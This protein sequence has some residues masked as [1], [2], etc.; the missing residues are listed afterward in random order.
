M[1][2]DQKRQEGITGFALIIPVC[3]SFI[4]TKTKNTI[5]D[6]LFFF[7]ASHTAAM[8]QIRCHVGSV[9]LISKCLL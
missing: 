8:P 9:T 2:L 5:N 6:C 1:N 7:L 4:K 3:I